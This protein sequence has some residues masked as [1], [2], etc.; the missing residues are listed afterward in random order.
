MV[1]P[2][3]GEGFYEMMCRL[4]LEQIAGSVSQLSTATF[5]SKHIPLTL[6]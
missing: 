2:N 3:V 5:T 1:E 4:A 6:L